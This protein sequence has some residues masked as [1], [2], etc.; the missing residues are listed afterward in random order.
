MDNYFWFS[1]FVV[2]NAGIL[3]ILA[4]N[5]SRLRLKLK[6]SLGD[7]GHKELLSAI[8]AQAN[9]IEQVPIFA[10]MLLALTLEHSSEFLLGCLALSFTFA[11]IAHAYGMLG[12]IFLGRRIGAG[13]TFLL[14]LVAIMLLTIELIN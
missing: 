7:G 6:V 4:A 2:L 13:L 14:Q 1:L 10:L 12:R 3:F 9:G 5:V 8:R 11:R